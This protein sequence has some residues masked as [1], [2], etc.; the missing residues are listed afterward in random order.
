MAEKTNVTTESIKIAVKHIF[1]GFI[2][3][4]LYFPVWLISSGAKRIVMNAK[5]WVEDYAH[6]FALPLLAKSLF[7]PM[8]GQADWQGRII[9]FFVR[10]VHLIILSVGW[11]VWSSIVI[12]I[13]GVIL[14]FPVFVL[15]AM[16][17]QFGIIPQAPFYWF[18]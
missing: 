17:Y 4:V 7:K 14:L 15:W 18:L 6:R 5:S 12:A 3:D 1:R 11:T 2:W 9:S 16:L 13:T 10:L 8:F